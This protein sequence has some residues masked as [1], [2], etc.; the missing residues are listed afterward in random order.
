MFGWEHNHYTMITIK[1]SLQNTLKCALM[2]LQTTAL[3]YLS[4]ILLLHKTFIV[5]LSFIVSVKTACPRTLG[6][7]YTL[8][9]CNF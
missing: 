2:Y 7:Q 9:I 3:P 4:V 8:K 1:E 5:S 6:V